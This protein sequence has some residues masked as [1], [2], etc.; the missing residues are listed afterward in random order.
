MI[1]YWTEQIGQTLVPYKYDWYTDI[2]GYLQ[3]IAVWMK[4]P[5]HGRLHQLPVFSFNMNRFLLL[6]KLSLTILRL[7]LKY[8][9]VKVE[10]EFVGESGTTTGVTRGDA[11]DLPLM[12]R[13][14]LKMRDMEGDRANGFFVTID[15]RLIFLMLICKF[16]GLRIFY[17][18]FW[19]TIEQI[20][21]Y[22]FILHH[23]IDCLNS[24]GTIVENISVD[25]VSPNYS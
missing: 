11:L 19:Y 5:L 12:W 22:D 6:R 16:S 18:Y 13:V 25:L 9:E 21:K 20:G 14:S 1:S 8:N 24:K 7:Q 17:H 2:F 4:C 23:K 3:A 10:G 15:N